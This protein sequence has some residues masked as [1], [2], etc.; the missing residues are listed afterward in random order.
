MNLGPHATFI[1][2]AYA[3]AA[4]ILLALIGWIVGDHRAQ[5]RALDELE[6]SGAK[7]RSSR[8]AS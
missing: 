1:V 3:T 8:G 6:A 4:F 5:K 2:V 7:R